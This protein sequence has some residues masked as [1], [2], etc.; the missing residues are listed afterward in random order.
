[1]NRYPLWSTYNHLHTSLFIIWSAVCLHCMAALFYVW[2]DAT[3]RQKTHVNVLSPRLFCR[4]NFKNEWV[5]HRAAAGRAGHGSGRVRQIFTGRVGSRVSKFWNFH[6]SGRVGS[7]SVVRVT[8]GSAGRPGSSNLEFK[9]I[10]F[11]C[12][13]TKNYWFLFLAEKCG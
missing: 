13:K 2:S 7:P 8:H 9:I 10:H 11:S 12:Q 1:M 3:T 5:V 6:G 4:R